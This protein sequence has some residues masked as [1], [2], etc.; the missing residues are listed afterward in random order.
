MGHGRYQQ[1][2]LTKADYFTKLLFCDEQAGTHPTFDLITLSPT[3]HMAADGFD[4]RESG[5][6]DI[7][8]GQSPAKLI[9]YAQFMHGER[10]F[11]SFLQTA[12]GT[13]IQMHQLMMQPF[14]RAFGVLV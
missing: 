6:D 2:D 8:A 3:L 12:G 11:E 9:G 13:R 10:L 5:F 7:G 14:Q 4:N 1:R